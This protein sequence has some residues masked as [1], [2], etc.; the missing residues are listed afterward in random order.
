M[1]TIQLLVARARARAGLDACISPGSLRHAFAVHLLEA[2]TDLRVVQGPVG[3]ARPQPA[4]SSVRRYS[5]SSRMLAAT[6][7]PMCPVAA[8]KVA[9]SGKVPAR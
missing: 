7:G 4:V 3:H 8:W 2:G 1:R 9:W 6:V 5:R